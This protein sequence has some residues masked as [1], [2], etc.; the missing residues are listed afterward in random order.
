GVSVFYGA[1]NPTIALAEVR[2]PVD[3]RTLVG[4]FE[5]T[6]PLRVLDIEALRKLN[7]EGSIFDQ[8]YIER[9]RKAKFLR[10]LSSRISQPIMP[11]DEPFDYLPTQAIADF[12]ATRREPELDG[13][14]YP[15]VQGTG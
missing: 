5:I 2:P 7:V 9:L 3:S 14:L 12:L 6:R 11:N 8:T 1:T 4:R 13:I 15:S 10:W